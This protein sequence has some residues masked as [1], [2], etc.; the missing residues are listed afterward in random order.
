M[1]KIA[2][3]GPAAMS[4]QLQIG[5]KILEVNRNITYKHTY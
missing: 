3:D 2:S 1:T 4:G 5:D